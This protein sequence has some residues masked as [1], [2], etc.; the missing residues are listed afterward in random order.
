MPGSEFVGFSQPGFNS[1]AA[2]N[3]YCVSFVGFKPG[4]G[5]TITGGDPTSA[6][7]PRDAS[8]RF[9]KPNDG[10]KW[11]VLSRQ[12]CTLALRMID[13]V[14]RDGYYYDK[15]SDKCLVV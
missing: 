2:C 8:F 10:E 11:L 5:T 9:E 15:N 3:Q 14:E 6:V 7:S 12:V 13:R 1:E 4:R